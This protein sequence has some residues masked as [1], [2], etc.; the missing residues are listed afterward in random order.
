VS[1]TRSL[2]R[3]SA[4]W[5]EDA[6][7]HLALRKAARVG[8]GVRVY[9]RVNVV[10][11]GT[12]VVGDRVVIVSTPSPVTIVVERGAVLEIGD[13]ACVESGS[14]LR[15]RRRVLVDRGTRVEAGSVIDDMARG[16]GE[17]RVS[18]TGARTAPRLARIRAV[19]A[20]VVPAVRD[21]G[22]AD[23]VRHAPG[24][25]SLAA[26]H[27]IVALE[28]ELDV[29]LPHDFFAH[30]RTLESIDAVVRGEASP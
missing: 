24:W 6:R 29:H 22:P 1:M 16:D 7:A 8:R 27:V 2:V 13:D 26:L 30:A 17:L 15:A 3:V 12:L 5:T 23:D 21:V 9:G 28:R 4:K 25:D 19:M 14:V 18:T 10:C 20:S 11:H